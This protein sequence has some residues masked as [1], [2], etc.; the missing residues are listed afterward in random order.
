M[1]GDL[2]VTFL[3]HMLGRRRARVIALLKPQGLNQDQHPDI[4]VLPGKLY[5]ISEE[6]LKYRRINQIIYIYREHS[7]GGNQ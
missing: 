7:K 2:L 4:F 3:E 5:E 6:L 1:P